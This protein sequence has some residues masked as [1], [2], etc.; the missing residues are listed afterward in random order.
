MALT[1]TLLS[2][3]L[4]GDGGRKR[5][6]KVYSVDPS[7]SYANSGTT[8]DLI[9]FQGALNP[10]N[11]ERAK[12]ARTPDQGAILNQPVGYTA[13]LTLGTDFDTFGIRFFQSDDAVDPLDEVANG[14]YAA[15]LAADT[16]IRIELSGPAI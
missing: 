10:N 11:I 2:S 9:D 3:Q 8:G 15:E 14:A 6:K 13:V 1:L 4:E 12:F 5:I 7:A 16:G